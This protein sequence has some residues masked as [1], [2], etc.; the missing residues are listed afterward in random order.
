MNWHILQPREGSGQESFLFSLPVTAS[1]TSLASFD[2]NGDYLKINNL[3]M[4]SRPCYGQ[5]SLLSFDY[6]NKHCEV[7]LDTPVKFLVII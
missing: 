2:G 1:R 7:S 3:K 6:Q 5:S 4:Q